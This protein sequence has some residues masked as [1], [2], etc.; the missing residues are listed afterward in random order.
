MPSE[1]KKEEKRNASVFFCVHHERLIVGKSCSC[2]CVCVCGILSASLSACKSETLGSLAVCRG[3][4]RNWTRRN[5]AHSASFDA[6]VALLRRRLS[7]SSSSC[8][9]ILESGLPLSFC[10]SMRPAFLRTRNLHIPP[11]LL[12]SLCAP[13]I[14]L[15]F[16]HYRL[17]LPRCAR[18]FF[19]TLFL[20][21]CALRAK[22]RTILPKVGCFANL[23][24]RVFA[25][26]RFQGN[27][28]WTLTAERC[29]DVR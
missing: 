18:T 15:Q 28:D 1:R 7:S 21:V 22:I 3:I 12:F 29:R 27:Y 4:C 11:V 19:V 14:G 6:S 9:V 17:S 24:F 26:N 8:F 13:A 2:M 16:V 23:G 20:C 25:S 10:A 5:I